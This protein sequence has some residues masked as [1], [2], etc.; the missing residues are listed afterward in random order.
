MLEAAFAIPG[1]LD[2]PTGG[3]AYARHLL[4]ELPGAGVRARHLILPDGFPDPDEADLTAAAQRLAAVPAE[5]PL[6]VDGLAYGALPPLLLRQVR[7]PLVALVHHPLALE[8]GLS[9]ERRDA[10]TASER[11]ALALARSV[12]ATS[13][14]TARLLAS[15]YGVPA[16]KIA[17]AEPGTAPAPRAAGTRVP[18]AL[19][20]VGAVTPRKAYP[21]LVAAL[22]GIAG[23]WR[24]TVVGSLDRDPTETARLLTAI[25]AA[26]LR[27]RVV[28]AGAVDDTDRDA[29]LD[30]ADLLVS[31]SLLEGYGMA[32]AE[33]LARGLPVVASTG[34]A[35]G[36]T[37]PAGCGL[38]VPPGD[39]AALRAALA[40]MIAE[41]RLR[42]NCAEA[43]WAAG[44]RLPRWR[45]TA[46]RVA[47]VLKAAA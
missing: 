43:A 27:G 25:A 4:A 23:D 7:A 14:H 29:L 13:G 38:A 37:V 33:A 26:D 36:E 45:D 21:L 39:G 11:A 3:Y 19:V 24:L 5:Q 41:P 17:V 2:A 46:A 22:A 32:L 6:L 12:V 47:A 10:L 16:D 40:R 34:G 31:A 8:A 9:P 30:A 20:A 42:R 18:F 15:D 44:Q 1:D 35:A 28:L